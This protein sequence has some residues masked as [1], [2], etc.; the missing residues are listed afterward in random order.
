MELIAPNG[1]AV[2]TQF[3]TSNASVSTYRFNDAQTAAIYPDLASAFQLSAVN[4]VSL[5]RY[6]RITAAPGNCLSFRE[7]FVFDVSITNVA[8]YKPTSSSVGSSFTDALGTYTPRRP[9]AWTESL[10][11]RAQRAT[12]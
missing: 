8:L 12:W 9:W 4:L 10:T 5:P 11:W 6:V 7:L 1:T 3:I 2:A